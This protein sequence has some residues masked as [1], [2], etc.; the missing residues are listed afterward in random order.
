M[1]LTVLL[2]VLKANLGK[3]TSAAGVI[4]FDPPVPQF[5]REAV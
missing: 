3:D 4:N 2:G 1:I 5:K